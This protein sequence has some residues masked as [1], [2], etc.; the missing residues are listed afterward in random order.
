MKKIA[1]ILAAVMMMAALTACGGNTTES[2]PA[3]GAVAPEGTAVELMDKVFENVPTEIN[4]VTESAETVMS[5][6]EL[7][8]Y[9]TSIESMDGIVDVAVR[10]PMMGSQAYHVVMVRGDSAETAAELAQ[11]MYDNMDMARWVCVQATEKQAVFCGDLALFVMLEPLYGVTSD[12]IVE[13][14]TTVCGGTVDTIIK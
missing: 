13:G 9:L 14:F 1:L 4:L 11:H 8:T 2:T 3:A 10:Q 12:Q 7:F 6:G 5:D